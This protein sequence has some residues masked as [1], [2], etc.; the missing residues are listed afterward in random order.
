MG[1][2]TSWVKPKI[3]TIVAR[4]NQVK[5]AYFAH[6]LREWVNGFCLPPS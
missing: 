6:E 3:K 1:S 2:I 4:Y 5:H